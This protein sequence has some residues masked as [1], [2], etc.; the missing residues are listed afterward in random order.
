MTQLNKSVTHSDE[1]YF[2]AKRNNRK[3]SGLEKRVIIKKV[4][5]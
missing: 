4:T 2:S 5:G 3:L 1:F